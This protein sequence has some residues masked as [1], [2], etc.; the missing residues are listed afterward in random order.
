MRV[1]AE[2][3]FATIP[4]E[5]EAVRVEVARTGGPGTKTTVLVTELKPDGAVRERVLVSAFVDE[6][7]MEVC[8]FASVGS[9]G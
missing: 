7:L 8:P 2:D 3:P 4:D 5:G 1:A 6:K 9:A